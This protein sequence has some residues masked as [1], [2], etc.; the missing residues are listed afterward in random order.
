MLGGYSERNYMSGVIRL[1]HPDYK[2]HHFIRGRDYF[3]AYGLKVREEVA[4]RF[5]IVSFAIREAALILRPAIVE[6]ALSHRHYDG[7]GRDHHV[8]VNLLFS[9]PG[10][11]VGTNGQRQLIAERVPG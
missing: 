11:H 10:P 3:V 9:P 5:T 4:N 7:L 2:R 1:N 6:I 8:L